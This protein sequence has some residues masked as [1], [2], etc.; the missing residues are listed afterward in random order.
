MIV[1][2]ILNNL[3][4]HISVELRLDLKIEGVAFSRAEKAVLVKLNKSIM[5]QRDV[6]AH[7]PY[8]QMR[9]VLCGAIVQLLPSGA[10]NTAKLT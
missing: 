2:V 1:L 7:R 3:G 4:S 10:L 5:D 6:I 9:R 8:D